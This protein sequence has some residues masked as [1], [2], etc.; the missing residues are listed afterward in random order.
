MDRLEHQEPT[1]FWSNK[2]I[3]E[4]PIDNNAK[5]IYIYLCRLAGKGHTTYPSYSTIGE[6]CSIKSRTTIK[7][8][9]DALM[10][11]GLLDYR[12]RMS[13]EGD[14]SS[15]IYTI[16]DEPNEKV[17]KKFKAQNASRE[18]AKGLP[19]EV[20]KGRPSHELP[21]PDNGQGSSLNEQPCPP[22]DPPEPDNGQPYVQNLDN[23][24][25]LDGHKEYLSKNRSFKN[26]S[27]NQD[28]Q[29]DHS[30]LFQQIGLDRIHHT[31]QIGYV[32][33]TL[34]DLLQTGR[35]GK[36]HLTQTEIHAAIDN[37]TPEIIDA[38]L[39]RFLNQVAQGRV[40]RPMDY[41]KTCF[42]TAGRDTAL[43]KKAG[44]ADKDHT[45]TYDMAEYVDLS[46]RRL[47]ESEG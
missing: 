14:R 39:D 6:K 46:M 44:P 43:Q 17:I 47:L 10:E 45:P 32:R 15:N 38:V 35:I 37:L 30:K 9:I 34:S 28:G 29:T 33:S 4:L 12:P 25:P 41:L 21:C 24:S 23:R 5:L 2:I 20:D 1:W 19:E 16:Y 8:A 22:D 18:T 7:K 11:A 13:K 3:F 31:E 26:Q 27:V 40:P 36:L 42:L